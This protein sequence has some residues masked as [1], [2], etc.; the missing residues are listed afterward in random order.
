[1]KENIEKMLKWLEADY[2]L[3]HVKG[4]KKAWLTKKIGINGHN[5]TKGAILTL[6]F[7][8]EGWEND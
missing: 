1:M 2:D 3:R 6:K 7:I 5:Q 4:T 8:L